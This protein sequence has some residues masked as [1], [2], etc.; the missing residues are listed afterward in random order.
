MIIRVVEYIVIFYTYKDCPGVGKK[1]KKNHR[2]K[3]GSIAHMYCGDSDLVGIKL[4][5]NASIKI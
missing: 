4:G 1:I 2:H 5:I 3:K